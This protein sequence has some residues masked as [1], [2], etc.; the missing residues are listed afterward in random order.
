MTSTLEDRIRRVFEA[1]ANQASVPNDAW[2]GPT[3]ELAAGPQSRRRPVLML[4]AVA[5][6]IVVVAGTAYLVTRPNDA[7]PGAWQPAGV[8]YPIVDL[9]PA[10]SSRNLTTAS[11][12]RMIQVPGQPVATLTRT[13]EYFFGPTAVEMRCVELSG[14]GCAP[15]WTWGRQPDVSISSSVDNHEA[16]EDIWMWNGLPAGT[17]YVAYIDGDRHLWQRPISGFAAFPDVAG[18]NEVVTAYSSEGTVLGQVGGGVASPPVGG[19]A[20]APMNADVSTT[21][22]AELEALTTTTMR[23][24]L[25]AAGATW[26][27]VNVATFAAGVDGSSIWAGCV[28]TTKQIVG[29]RVAAMNVRMYDSAT[30]RPQNPNSPLQTADPADCRT[31]S[32]NPV[33]KDCSVSG[34]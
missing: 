18:R 10:T 6:A 3:I 27:A 34:P 1:D 8:E 20:T 4:A 31:V 12:S 33:I 19:E 22:F 28:A 25:D 24:C 17:A 11:L 14:E 16:S 15:D 2:P 13:V 5:A 9:G 30:A 7:A 32:T 23:D 26:P 21:Q 29:D